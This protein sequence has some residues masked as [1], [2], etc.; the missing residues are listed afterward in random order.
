MIYIFF[1]NCFS[2]RGIKEWQLENNVC[3]R[4]KDQET[5]EEEHWAGIH[6]TATWRQGKETSRGKSL[7]SSMCCTR[8]LVIPGLFYF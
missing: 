5:E 3:G 1:D 2:E 6:C 4:G 8:F 7:S